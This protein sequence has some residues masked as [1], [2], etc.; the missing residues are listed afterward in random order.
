MKTSSLLQ[1]IVQHIAATGCL[2][3]FLVLSLQSCSTKHP[4][5]STAPATP[6]QTS[7]PGPESVSNAWSPQLLPVRRQYLIR[8]SSTISINNDTTARVEPIESTMIYTI[9]ITDTAG[10][11]LLVG[12]IDSLFVNSRLSTK[13]NTDISRTAEVHAFISRQGQVGTVSNI[14][15]ARCAGGTTFP[16]S[17]LSE[18]LTVLPGHPIKVGDTWSDTS[19]TT[20]CHGKI[21]LTQRAV[22]QYELLDFSSCQGGGVKVRRTVSETMAGASAESTN[23]LSAI[24]SGT[25]ISIL[26]LERNTGVLLSSDGESHL[27]LTVMTIRGV[28]PFTQKTNTHIEAQ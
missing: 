14:A 7:K 16:T 27:D 24:G 6:T 18:L 10:A 3:A 12:H 25:A 19:S 9:S 22:Q 21:P 13:P 4:P 1:H 15:P 2:T 20:T 26:C 23:H 17:R 5:T 11:F 8:D 28:F